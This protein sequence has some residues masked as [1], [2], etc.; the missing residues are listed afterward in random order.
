MFT[1]TH[2]TD[3]HLLRIAIGLCLVAVPLALLL[4]S[5]DRRVLDETPRDDE[6]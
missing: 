5:V 4:L 1:L 2:T 6:D 3:S